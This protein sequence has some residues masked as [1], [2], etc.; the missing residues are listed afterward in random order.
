MSF[1]ARSAPV[2]TAV[3]GLGMYVFRGA[4]L[5]NAFHRGLL[6]LILLNVLLVGVIRITAWKLDLRVEQ[7]APIDSLIMAGLLANIAMRYFSGLWWV[8]AFLLLGATLSVLFSGAILWTVAVTIPLVPL[9]VAYSW[10]RAAQAARDSADS[11][12]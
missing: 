4:L 5:R 1:Y 3:V 8:V 10:N 9:S 6:K 2:P 11:G 7:Y 12:A